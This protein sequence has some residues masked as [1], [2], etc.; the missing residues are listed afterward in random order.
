MNKHLKLAGLI[1]VSLVLPIIP[2]AIFVE[3]I[4]SRM[5]NQPTILADRFVRLFYND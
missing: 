5:Y 1:V 3:Y 4:A 2:A